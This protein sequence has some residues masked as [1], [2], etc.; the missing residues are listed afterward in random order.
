MRKQRYEVKENFDAVIRVFYNI[1]KK[2][3]EVFEVDHYDDFENDTVDVM[4]GRDQWRDYVKNNGAE[5]RAKYEICK[6]NDR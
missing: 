2:V 5:I 3:D 6:E 4:V 1:G